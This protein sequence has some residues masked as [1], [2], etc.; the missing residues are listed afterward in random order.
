VRAHVEVVGELGT[1]TQLVVSIEAPRLRAR[2]RAR[3]RVII[4]VPAGESGPDGYR[5]ELRDGAARVEA[6]TDAG[7][8]YAEQTLRALRAA[9]IADAQIADRPRFLWRGAMLDVARHF[10]GVADVRRV[11]DHLAA[12]KLNVLHL[13][14]TDDQG[15]R[16]AID[17]WPRLA[18]HGGGTAVGGGAGGFY[19]KDDYRRI[20]AYAAKRFVTVVPEIDC[21]GHVQAALASY[22][23]L[24]GGASQER[25]TGTE[26][27]FSSLDAHADLTYR[28]LGDVF[29]E[30]AALTPGPFLHIGGDEAHSTSCEDY[31]AFMARVQPLVSAHGKRIAGWEEIASA[32]LLDG[33]VVQYWNTD[34]PRGHELARA[35]AEQGAQLV[36]SPADRVYLDIKYAADFPLG[37]D[38]AGLVDVRDSYDWDPATL[39]DGVPESAIVGVEAPLWTETIETLADVE[40]MLFPRLCAVAEVAWSPQA[41]RDWEDFRSRLAAER[42]RWDDAGVAYHRSPQVDWE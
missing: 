15:W 14:L 31:L 40:T 41:S 5:L 33:A 29:G 23:D 34:N 12:Y 25:Y 7:R 30:L 24:N 22:P 8:F 19:T 9:G 1:E 16:L 37:Q 20:V 42:P 17:A 32:P 2:R 11:I 26:V 36:L 28:F 10:F 27:G 13:H 4:P 6:E 38:W 3:A 18:E 21:P 35:A 39:V